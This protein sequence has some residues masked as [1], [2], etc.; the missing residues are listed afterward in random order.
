M[1]RLCVCSD[2][3]AD[4]LWYSPQEIAEWQARGAVG[5]KIWVGVSP[6]VD[7]PA[8]DPTLEQPNKDLPIQGEV[9]RTRRPSPGA[10]AFSICNQNA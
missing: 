10:R 6:L 9:Q 7:D 3:I 1:G 8:N 5:Y 2:R 4:G